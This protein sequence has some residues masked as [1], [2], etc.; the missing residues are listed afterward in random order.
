VEDEE[1]GVFNHAAAERLVARQAEL[2]EET[3]CPAVLHIYA[4]T[5]PAFSRYLEFA[6]QAWE[7]PFIIDSAIVPPVP[8][9][10]LW[11]LSW[12][13]GSGNFQ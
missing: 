12:D 5:V 7:G 2:S 3:G 11:S 9:L 8:Q 13:T 4:R 1:L 6:E 10:H